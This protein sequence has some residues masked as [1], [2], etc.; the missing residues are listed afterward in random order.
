MKYDQ[1]GEKFLMENVE[2]PKLITQVYEA[3]YWKDSI[4]YR[5]EAIMILFTRHHHFRHFC[6]ESGTKFSTNRISICIQ[7]FTG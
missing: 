7:C 6:L 1:F 2:L 3:E 4:L 5:P